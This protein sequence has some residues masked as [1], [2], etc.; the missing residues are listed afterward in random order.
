[1]IRRWM[2]FAS[3]A[4]LM[5]DCQMIAACASTE[6]KKST[7]GPADA[8]RQVLDTERAWVAAEI[9]RDAAAQRR[10]I[11]DKFVVTFGAHNPHDKEA[12]MKQMA[13]LPVDP[14]ETQNLTGETVIVDGDTAVVVGTDTLRGT[15]GGKPYTLV[16]RYTT[17]YVRREGQW[18]ALAEQMAEVPR[19]K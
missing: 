9:K 11:D 6:P 13:R 12:F 7:V 16:A 18:L 14:T 3:V 4:V 5:L 19:A 1:M 2:F 10:I 8:R 17:T 15:E